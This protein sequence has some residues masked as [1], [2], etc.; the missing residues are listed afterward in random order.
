MPRV[1]MSE[2]ADAIEVRGQGFELAFDRKSGTISSFKYR[3]TELVRSGPQP[4]FWRPPTD[5][6]RGNRMPGRC[7]VWRNAGRD[8]KVDSVDAAKTA[9]C[10]V[11]VTVKSRLAAN[12]SPYESTFTVY[13]SGDVVVANRF[14]PK[15][16]L[17]ELM[18]FGMQ[19]TVPAGFERFT[20]Y[21]RGP[22]ETHWDRKLGARVGVWSGTVDEQF[23]DYSEPQENGNK[24]DVRWAALEGEGGAGLLVVGMP[25]LNV[26]ALHYTTADL[27]GAKHT[28][29]MT[30][31]DFVTLN[32]DLEQ[33]GVGGDNSW[34]ARPHG[35]CTLAPKPYSYSFRLRPFSRGE[36]PAELARQRMPGQD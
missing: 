26:S 22:Q 21:G 29:E 23:V 28:F 35:W 34:G 1:E 19:M 20:W 25:L 9:E 13:G 27:E 15:G 14:E 5:N 10:A 24:A 32:I 18:R 11:R 8:R 33:T 2:R 31:R 7:G 16:K 17:P 30:K 6:D 4:H 3:G 12:D 36:A